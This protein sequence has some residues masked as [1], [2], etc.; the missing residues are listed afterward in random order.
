MV[1]T[2]VNELKQFLLAGSCTTLMTCSFVTQPASSTSCEHYT[3]TYRRPRVTMGCA[4]G[5]HRLGNASSFSQA[6]IP[7]FGNTRQQTSGR[8]SVAE[9]PGSLVED[10]MACTDHVVLLRRFSATVLGFNDAA[11]ATDRL[12]RLPT[13]G[14]GDATARPNAM[15]P[16]VPPIEEPGRCERPSPLGTSCRSVH[17]V[18]ESPPSPV[19]STLAAHDHRAERRG[20]SACE[21]G[22]PSGGCRLACYPAIRP[23]TRSRRSQLE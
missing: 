15:G 17:E 12:G 2:Y 23:G 11:P 13:Q 4:A 6:G 14:D 22:R 10:H 8:Q 3:A 1:C 5:S 20:R 7:H 9:N 18:C 16:N 19:G 21:S